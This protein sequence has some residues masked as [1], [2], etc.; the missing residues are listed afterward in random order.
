MLRC[1]RHAQSFFQRDAVTLEEAPERPNPD[2]AFP[3]LS[4]KFGE[5]YIGLL[6][7]RAENE[8]RLGL[9]AL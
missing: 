3:Q 2:A 9:D 8:C 1:W 4:F 5:R 7:H 6:C